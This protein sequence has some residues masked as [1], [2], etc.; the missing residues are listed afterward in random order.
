MCHVEQILGKLY[1]C[2]QPLLWLGSWERE[3]EQFDV[4]LC[5]SCGTLVRDMLGTGKHVQAWKLD[6]NIGD[7][8]PIYEPKVFALVQKVQID[9]E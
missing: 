3:K 2:Q 5:V 7:M 1:C 8:H 6:G 9:L 4:Y